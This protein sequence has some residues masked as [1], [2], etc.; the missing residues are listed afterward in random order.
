MLAMFAVAA[1][2]M[3]GTVSLISGQSASAAGAT[4]T[5]D[6]NGLLR[7]DPV[8]G[9]NFAIG[10]EYYIEDA[11]KNFRSDGS[12]RIDFKDKETDSFIVAGHINVVKGAGGNN[13]ICAEEPDEEIS[14]KG[15]GGPHT[16]NNENAVST[17]TD[18]TPW[19]SPN[20]ADTIDIGVI[21]F[22]GTEGRLRPEMTHPDYGDPYPSLSG[23]TY[24]NV[25]LC[26]ASQDD[27][28]GFYSVKINLDTNCNG[29][30]DR[31]Y[32][33]NYIDTSGLGPDGKPQNKWTIAQGGYRTYA[34]Q[35]SPTQIELKSIFQYW[36]QYSSVNH[37]AYTYQTVRVDHQDQSAWQSTTDPPYKFITLKQI[38]GIKNT[39]CPTVTATNPAP[40]Y[41]GTDDSG[42]AAAVEEETTPQEQLL[43][44]T[45]TDET[46]STE[47]P[48]LAQS[49]DPQSED[50]NDTTPDDDNDNDKKKNND[51]NEEEEEEKEQ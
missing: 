43:E 31:V 17:F 28:I 44:R 46:T 29:K 37:P 9:H 8:A 49:V 35:F 21:N 38:T 45:T 19:P 48:E 18:I 23:N 36:G 6:P 14:V 30:Y 33:V 10:N 7:L 32:T 15:N 13:N 4:G 22:A 20:S 11:I 42:L 50:D 25:D 12:E 3:L 47:E 1:I 51:K 27:W 24:P 26:N 16:D 41:P 5:L 34:A 39:D 2:L 40:R